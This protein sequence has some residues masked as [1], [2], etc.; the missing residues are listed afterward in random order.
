[1]AEK[2]APAKLVLKPGMICTFMNTMAESVDKECLQY[3][4]VN[5]TGQEL[6]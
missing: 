2:T 3:T 6:E 5:C 4:E 1:M